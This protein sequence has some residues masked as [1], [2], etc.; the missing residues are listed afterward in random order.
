M[1]QTLKSKET[2]QSSFDAQ[3]FFDNF[4]MFANAPNAVAKM[5]ELILQLAVRS[6]LVP[7]DP[8]D[9]PASLLKSRI[10]LKN[11]WVE[12][13]VSNQIDAES[14]WPEGIVPYLLPDSWEWIRLSELGGFLGGGTPSKER[15]EFWKGEIP[16]VSPKDM[17]RPCLE[18]AI[19]HI[20]RLGIENS[21]AKMIAK[22]SLLMVVRGIILVH[23]FPVALAMKELTINQDMKALYLAIPE[24]GEYLLTCLAAEKRRVLKYVERSSHGTCRLPTNSIAN[25]PIPLP[26]LAEQKRIVSKV[27][28]LMSLC[29]ALES[30]LQAT[31]SAS[32]EILSAAVSHLLAAD[33][34]I[35]IAQTR[36]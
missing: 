1:T 28:E 29:D 20:S 25:F 31:E 17:K 30:Q 7:Q 32:A 21:S 33:G 13:T 27:T 6:K 23:S 15:A 3:T 10:N 18:D 22:G 19:D 11:D 12:L 5:R 2:A 26:P 24:M 8:K 35:G 34:R 16:W 9:E 36:R 4:E 14:I